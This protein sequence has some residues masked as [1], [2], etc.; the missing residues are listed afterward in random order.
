MNSLGGFVAAVQELRTKW[1]CKEWRSPKP[2]RGELWFRAEDA[3]HEATR[4]QPG[5][6]RPHDGKK[7]RSIDELFLIEGWMYREASRSIER[8]KT[9]RRLGLGVVLPNAASWRA[10][11]HSGLDGRFI[12]RFAFCG[13]YQVSFESTSRV[14]A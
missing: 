3:S 12:D 2:E 11:S 7:P 6:Y 4:L 9:G 8:C 14:R 10:N 1:K 13:I 5:L